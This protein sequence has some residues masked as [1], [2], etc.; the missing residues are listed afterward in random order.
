MRPRSLTKQNVRRHVCLDS[1]PGLSPAA[2][3]RM[4]RCEPEARPAGSALTRG[5]PQGTHIAVVYL[6]R[7]SPERWLWLVIEFLSQ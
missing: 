2:F 6:C 1:D 7:Y 3:A 4:L 5:A